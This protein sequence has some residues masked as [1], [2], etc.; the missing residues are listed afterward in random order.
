MV[1]IFQGR[2][3]HVSAYMKKSLS[4]FIVLGYLYVSLAFIIVPS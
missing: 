3:N 2:S 1:V 4:D